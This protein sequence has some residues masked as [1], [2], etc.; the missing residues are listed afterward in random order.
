MIWS[1]DKA[2]LPQMGGRLL[3]GLLF[4]WV[5]HGTTKKMEDFIVAVF[6]GTIFLM[7]DR[8]FLPD[9]LPADLPKVDVLMSL[10]VY[11]PACHKNGVTVDQAVDATRFDDFLGCSPG[12]K[13]W[14]SE[15][16]SELEALR[17]QMVLEL[18]EALATE[19]WKM[20]GTRPG[21]GDGGPKEGD[22]NRKQST[23]E[24]YW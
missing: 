9:D 21:T 7:N 13:P 14:F 23:K 1:M 8:R 2:G 16:M 4:A 18:G 24:A 20:S 3:M 12:P 22:A 11:D 15:W 10:L 17:K 6:R 19:L 5:T